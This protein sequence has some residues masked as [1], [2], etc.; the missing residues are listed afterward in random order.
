MSKNPTKCLVCRYSLQVFLSNLFDDRYGYPGSYSLLQCQRCG[1]LVLD[2]FFSPD[3]LRKL[4][5]D[6]Y[7]RSSLD[8]ESYCPATRSKGVLG[9]LKGEKRSAYQWVPEKVRVLDIGC[10]FGQTLGYHE[11]RGCL[12]YGVEADEN[13]KR[14]A[15]RH[16]FKVHVGLFDPDLY[17]VDFFDYVT[18][19]QVI[20]HDQDL[21]RDLSG[22]HRI[23]KKD[24]KLILSTPNAFGWGAKLFGRRWINWHIP[25]H[26]N[27]I[28]Q[29]SM[30]LLAEQIGFEVEKTVT[31]THSSWLYYQLCHL[32]N[33]PRA[34]EKSS[35]WQPKRT[36]INK[37]TC[38]PF[39]LMHKLYILAIITRIFDMLNLGDNM[40]IVLKKKVV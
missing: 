32:V 9:W 33:Y 1:H 29:H 19:D 14:V 38:S 36:I 39:T 11:S 3:Q 30:D 20:E 2:K 27:F 34:G 8:L 25:Y 22:I 37:L 10:G 13:I 7:P 26:Y 15:D 18:M 4:Y 12:A 40:L 35:F 23:L 21:M 5:T 17:E 28:S 24:G 16:G 31:L 6:Y